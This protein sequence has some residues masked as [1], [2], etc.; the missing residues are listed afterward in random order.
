MN[1]TE[2]L[3]ANIVVFDGVCNLC[4]GAVNFIIKRD[5]KRIFYFSS[6]QSEIGAKLLERH[7]INANDIDTFLLIRN[8]KPYTKSEAALIIARELNRPWNWLFFLKPIPKHLRDSIYSLV[9]RNRYK[10]SGIRSYCML[11]TSEQKARFIL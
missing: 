9:A 5:I 10:W 3:P 6:I 8:N 2:T 4:N 1:S 7:N 11:P